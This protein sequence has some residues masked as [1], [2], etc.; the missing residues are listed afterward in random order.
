MWKEIKLE[1]SEKLAYWVGVAQADGCY[2]K[3]IKRIVVGI[4]EKSL[5]ML[6]KFHEISKDLLKGLTKSQPYERN[7]LWRYSVGIT[8]IFRSLKQLRVKLQDPPIPPKWVVSKPEFLGAYLSG[9]IDGDGDVRIKRPKYPQCAIRIASGSPQIKLLQ[10]IKEKL[11]CGTSVGKYF[12]KGYIKEKG[13]IIKGTG[14][15]IEFLVSPKTK[16]F[17]IKYLL[18][19]IQLQYKKEKIESYLKLKGFL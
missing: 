17:V 15:E 4:H 19:W 18:P 10:V 5:Q 2:I 9:L 8:K 13:K 1:P 7:G 11:K 3:E 6:V 16:D 12:K 14:Y